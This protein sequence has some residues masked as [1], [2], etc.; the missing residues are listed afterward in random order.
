[1]NDRAH[2]S[3]LVL[4]HQNVE[5]LRLPLASVD[6]MPGMIDPLVAQADVSAGDAKQLVVQL[7][8]KLAVTEGWPTASA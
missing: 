1:V 8:A 7:L 2:P 5:V 3:E 4:S 6:E